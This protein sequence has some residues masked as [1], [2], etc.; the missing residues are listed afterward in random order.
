MAVVTGLIIA[1]AYGVKRLLSRTRLAGGGAKILN[2][3]QTLC[4]GTRRH[5]FVLEAGSRLLIVGAAGDN[6]RLLATLPNTSD[7][8]DAPPAFD[9]VLGEAEAQ[10]VGGEGPK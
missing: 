5:I 6:M 3:R 8:I 7:G 2:V 10:T 1:A 9:T 4:V